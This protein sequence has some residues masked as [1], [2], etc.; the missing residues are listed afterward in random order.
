[1]PV[2]PLPRIEIPI[3]I[4]NNKNIKIIYTNNI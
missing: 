3:V 2:N 4:I 1:M